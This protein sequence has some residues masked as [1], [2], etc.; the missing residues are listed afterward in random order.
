MYKSKTDK[1]KRN[2]IYYLLL[3][4]ITIGMGLASRRY[5]NYLPEFVNIGLG[6]TLWALMLYW[7]IGFLFRTNSILSNVLISLSGCF[8]VELSQLINTGWLNALRDTTLG[9]LVLGRGFL[10]S[11]FVA[12]TCGVGIGMVMERLYYK[13][14]NR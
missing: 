1:I 5:S 4:G 12:Y 11:D 7:T 3:I 13:T 2:R 8:L 14:A 10:W 6:D 9:A